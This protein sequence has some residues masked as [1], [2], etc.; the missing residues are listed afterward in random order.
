ML[1]RSY[2][3]GP[4]NEVATYLLGAVIRNSNQT[5]IITD[6]EAYGGFDDPA[7]HA[8]KGATNRNRSMF[9]QA[10]VLYVYL[11]YGIHRCINVVTDSEGI[12]GAILIRGGLAITKN[13]LDSLGRPRISVIS[14]PGR[15]GKYLGAELSDDGVDLFGGL[16]WQ[17]RGNGSSLSVGSRF[18]TGMRIGISKATDFPWRYY[19]EDPLDTFSEQELLFALN[20]Q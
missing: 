11:S 18:S 20:R 5:L 6:T 4:A 3:A 7:S 8:F 9:G 13:E 14:G 10:G 2:L 12:G 15:V 16:N 17:L 19:L 1:D